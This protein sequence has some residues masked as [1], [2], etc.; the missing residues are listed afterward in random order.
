MGFCLLMRECRQ[1]NTFKIAV[2]DRISLSIWRLD[3]KKDDILNL[4]K[5]WMYFKDKYDLRNMLIAKKAC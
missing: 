1:C 5:R 2:S 3:M 4:E